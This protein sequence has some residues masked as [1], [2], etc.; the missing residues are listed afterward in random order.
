MVECSHRGLLTI[1]VVMLE[2]APGGKSY[3]A[4]NGENSMKEMVACIS[5]MRGLGGRTES[6][7]IAEVIPEHGEAIAALSFCANS[8]VRAARAHG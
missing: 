6:L 2:R 7:T 3:Y 1:Y 4:A 8:R 5:R